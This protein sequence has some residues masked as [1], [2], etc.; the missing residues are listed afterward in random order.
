MDADAVL[1]IVLLIVLAA[2]IVWFAWSRRV[3]R[4]RIRQWADGHNCA[5][6]RLE[7]R[8]SLIALL[9]VVI[10]GWIPFYQFGSWH[11]LMQ[12]DEGAQRWAWI[13]F[14]QQ[15]WLDLPWREICVRWQ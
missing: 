15:W 7:Y 6:L 10:V 4:R 2:R 8:W 13:T 12:D 3:C 5:L 9:M 1:M 14:G 11:A